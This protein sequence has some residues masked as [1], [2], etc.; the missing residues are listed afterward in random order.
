MLADALD[1]ELTAIE[2]EIDPVVVDDRTESGHITVEPGEVAGISQSAVGV[3]DGAERITLDLRMS[4]NVADS[5]DAIR[6]EGEPDIAYTIEDGFHGDVTT[7]A[8]V[9]NTARSVRRAEPGLAT[10]LDIALAGSGRI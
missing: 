6:I 9:V 1:W 3:V 8:V 5:Y 7:P 10:M 2:Q 4:L